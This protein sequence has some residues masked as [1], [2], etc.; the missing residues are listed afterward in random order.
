MEARRTIQDS[1]LWV[2][3]PCLFLNSQQ[4]LRQQFTALHANVVSAATAKH[5]NSSFRFYCLI[6]HLHVSI[7]LWP[8]YAY[9]LCRYNLIPLFQT[10]C[11]CT[12]PWLYNGLNDFACEFSL[13]LV[14]LGRKCRSPVCT[15]STCTAKEQVFL[16]VHP[17]VHH[18]G[19]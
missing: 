11:V 6:V 19:E 4:F 15:Y 1:S 12:G 10:D 17:P 16:S 2:K 18:K 3:E 8:Y 5:T 9:I 7:S 13:F 14:A